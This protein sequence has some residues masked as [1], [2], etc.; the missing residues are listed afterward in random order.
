LDFSCDADSD[1][2]RT[3]TTT[4]T[5]IAV[6]IATLET[7]RV[8]IGRPYGHALTVACWAV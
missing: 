6:A 1:F 2:Q 5:S 4:T 8:D 3:R 7:V